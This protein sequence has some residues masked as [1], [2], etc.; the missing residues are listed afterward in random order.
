LQRL[1][2]QPK[3]GASGVTPAKSMAQEKPILDDQA[4]ERLPFCI[5]FVSP[6]PIPAA[7]WNEEPTRCIR[8]NAE[9]CSY[10]LGALECLDQPDT[11]IGTPEQVFDAR[12]QVKE[13]MLAVMGA[14]ECEECEVGVTG[15]RFDGCVMQQQI[16]GEWV[17]IPGYDPECFR[18]EKGDTGDTGATGAPGTPGTPGATGAKGDTGDTGE[19]GDTGDVGAQG[20]PGENGIC[21][22]CGDAEG[23]EV[24]SEQRACS[25]ASYV[26]DWADDIFGDL[27]TQIDIGGN[28]TGIVSNFLSVIPGVNVITTVIVGVTS[29]A[30]GTATSAMRNDV[31]TTYLEMLKCS[32]YCDVLGKLTYNASDLR[33]WISMEFG[34]AGA[35]GQQIYLRLLDGM[36]DGELNKRLNVGAA[37]TETECDILCDCDEPD[38]NCETF[39][40]SIDAQGCTPRLSGVSYIPGVGFRSAP[41]GSQDTIGVVLP[42]RTRT[43]VSVQVEATN[44]VASN[45]LFVG[46]QVLGSQVDSGVAPYIATGLNIV[47]TND[48]LWVSHDYAPGGSGVH[49]V[50]VTKIIVCYAPI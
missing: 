3:I 27:L 41:G 2:K 22:D 48:H 28:I 16:D 18:G 6:V 10:I 15:I 33:A 38:P 30:V 14:Y 7:A 49:N 47:L 35:F 42:L 4:A 44:T 46:N 37:S 11:W 36:T 40:F 45:R 20:I 12:Q 29:S 25:I 9:W 21:E 34:L 1:R 8:V 5:P 13:I 17:D 39:D 32:L 43:V 26:V 23:S 50:T 31:S 19:K 24:D